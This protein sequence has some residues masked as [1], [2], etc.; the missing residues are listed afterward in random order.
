MIKLI[1]RNNLILDFLWDNQGLQTGVF[2]AY[3]PILA[4]ER[5]ILADT[6]FT[7]SDSNAQC[8]IRIHIVWH[9][10]GSQMVLYSNAWLFTIWTVSGRTRSPRSASMSGTVQ[11]PEPC[12]IGCHSLRIDMDCYLVP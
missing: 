9:L 11:H 1:S 2:N 12:R 3:T 5:G 6:R 4:R 10:D 7:H 8:P